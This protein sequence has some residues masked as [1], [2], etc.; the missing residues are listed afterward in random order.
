VGVDD[1]GLTLLDW[2][3]RVHDLYAAIRR[4]ADPASA[5]MLWRSGRD[6]LFARHPQSPLPRRPGGFTGIPVAPYDVRWR[7]EVPIDGDVEHVRIEVPTATDGMVPFERVGVARITDVGQLDVW[8][9]RSYGGGLFVPLR[10][11]TSGRSTYGGGRYLIDTV[12]GADLG[13]DVDLA[14]G[15]GTLVVDFNFAYHPSCA[16]EPA[17]TCPL[18]PSGNVL[19]LEVSAGEQLPVDG[20]Y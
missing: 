13:G 16:Y 1:H 17:W 15:A 19:D 7:F 4:T 5:H 8:A 2:R 12:K 10:D 6:D 18:A 3:R 20:W 9:L 14:T 11:G